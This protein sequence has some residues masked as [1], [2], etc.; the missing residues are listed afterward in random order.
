MDEGHVYCPPR[1][2]LYFR[3]ITIRIKKTR[4]SKIIGYCFE[5][6]WNFGVDVV[7][8]LLQ[9]CF[10]PS[11]NIELKENNSRFRLIIVLRKIWKVIE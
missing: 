8:L 1:K 9:P 11:S 6:N 4:S 3:R 10:H 2:A 7:P 5:E